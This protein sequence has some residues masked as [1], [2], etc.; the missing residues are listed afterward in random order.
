MHVRVTGGLRGAPLF[1]GAC[2]AVWALAGGVAYALDRPHGSPV[3]AVVV[4]TAGV[5]ELTPPTM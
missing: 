3:A 4:I 1:A 2:L 5:Y